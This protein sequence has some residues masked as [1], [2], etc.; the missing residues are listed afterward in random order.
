VADRYYRNCG[1]ELSPDDRFCPSCG[2]PLHQTV[3]V[4]TPEADVRVPQPPPAS[5]SPQPPLQAQQHPGVWNHYKRPILCFAGSLLAA[6]VLEAATKPASYWE[7]EES[8]AANAGFVMGTV[9]AAVIIRL[10]TFALLLLVLGA[11]FYLFGRLR[12]TKVTFLQAI[13]DWRLLVV[14][15]VLILLSGPV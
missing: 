15:V 7:W 12:G 8:A 9:L 11:G 2:G 6:G 14:M 1:Q 13:F 4:P 5:W 3:H 10:I